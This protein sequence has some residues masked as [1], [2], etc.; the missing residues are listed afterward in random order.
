MDVQIV[1]GAK[2]VAEMTHCDMVDI[3]QPAE[4]IIVDTPKRGRPAKHK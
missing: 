2:V 1:G 4:A 3:N